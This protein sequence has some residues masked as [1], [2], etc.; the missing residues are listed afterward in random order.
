VLNSPPRRTTIDSIPAQQRQ[1]Q[2]GAPTGVWNV[3]AAFPL[4]KNMPEEI[5][6]VP[7]A[8]LRLA[9]SA[10]SP[11]GLFWLVLLGTGLQITSFVPDASAVL[12]P[13]LAPSYWAPPNQVSPL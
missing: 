8:M 12:R 9:D 10:L 4:G 7:L 5:C 13:V 3:G 11:R 2:Q 1:S 6:F